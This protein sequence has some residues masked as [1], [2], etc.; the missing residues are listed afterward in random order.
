MQ[1]CAVDKPRTPPAELLPGSAKVGRSDRLLASDI[2][3]AISLVGQDRRRGEVNTGGV[4]LYSAFTGCCPVTFHDRRY[5]LRSTIGTRRA[6]ASSIIITQ[7]HPAR[8]SRHQRKYRLMK[9][10]GYRVA[11]Q[12]RSQTLPPHRRS[13]SSP[14][15]RRRRS[16]WQGCGPRCSEGV[17]FDNTRRPRVA[18]WWSRTPCSS[19]SRAGGVWT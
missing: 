14:R 3:G 13:R 19:R 18:A 7:R 11:P 15:R 12:L 2:G 1:L 16:A 8:T 9:G 5:G 10:K 17:R 6:V 4:P